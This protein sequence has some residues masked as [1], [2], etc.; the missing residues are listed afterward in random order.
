MNSPG[1]SVTE[2]SR[3]AATIMPEA[4]PRSDSSNGQPGPEILKFPDRPRP[5]APDSGDQGPLVG[6]LPRRDPETSEEGPTPP[7]DGGIGR[8]WLVTGSV[9]ALAFVGVGAFFT[10]GDRSDDSVMQ[11]RYLALPVA[12]AMILCAIYLIYR[13][14]RS[15]E[16]EKAEAERLAAEEAE[17]SARLEARKQ[18][19][20]VIRGKG[21][22]LDTQV[23]KP[24]ATE[25]APA[26]EARRP[27]E[28]PPENSVD[29]PKDGPAA[30]PRQV[31][32]A[33]KQLFSG[34]G[35]PKPEHIEILVGV[36]GSTPQIAKK[37]GDGLAAFVRRAR[38]KE[39]PDDDATSKPSRKG[40]E[41]SRKDQAR[42]VAVRALRSLAGITEVPLNKAAGGKP[43]QPSPDY[44][45]QDLSGIDARGLDLE[46]GRLQGCKFDD[47]LLSGTKFK[48]ADLHHASMV[49]ADLSEADFSECRMTGSD[50]AGASATRARFERADLSGAFMLRASLTSS[51]LAGA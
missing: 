15:A 17:E 13:V 2:F 8:G 39:N 28:R 30:T 23:E 24:P 31:E 22:Q 46:G 33:F 41:P 18:A 25:P 9:V 21:P 37:I 45:A 36:A 42:A 19:E 6:R 10:I 14:I 5:G 1:A 34:R 35:L 16:I 11:M 50:L 4:T 44:G 51:F 49:R 29:P 40:S 43:G 32:S 20:Q 48:K 3:R 38:A 12:V 47:A 26:P 27:A 7:S